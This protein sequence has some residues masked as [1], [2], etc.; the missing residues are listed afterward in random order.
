VTAGTAAIELPPGMAELAGAAVLMAVEPMR[1]DLHFVDA[2]TGPRRPL[3]ALRCLRI[4][5]FGR[6]SN[7]C[8]RVR[9][10]LVGAMRSGNYCWCGEKH[11]GDNNAESSAG[12][13]PPGCDRLLHRFLRE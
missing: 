3:S 11:H 2:F 12:V 7:S 8:C 6:A 5:F 13:R 1:R 9:P 4:L 10:A